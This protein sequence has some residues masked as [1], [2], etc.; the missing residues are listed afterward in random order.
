MSGLVDPYIDPETG[1][2]RDRIGARTQGDLD[3]A[4]GALT[5]FGLVE[6]A[7][8]YP[9]RA[10]GDVEELRGIHRHLF[11]DLY[12]WAGRVRSVDIRMPGGEPFLPVS[13][14]EVGAGFVFEQ[15]RA[16]NQLRGLDRAGF[17]QALA[18][19][20]DALNYVHPFR[21]GNGRTQRVFWS[22]V[23]RDAG[24]DVDWR[25]VSRERNDDASRAGIECGGLPVRRVVAQAPDDA[26]LR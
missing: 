26:P 1:V 13:R 3:R 18:R 17:V 20:Y 8:R 23:A 14:I 15:L 5:V 16:E 6:L 9:V 21:E 24:W 10:S 7:S 4:E 22:R 12:E 11:H 2:L 19:H 25:L